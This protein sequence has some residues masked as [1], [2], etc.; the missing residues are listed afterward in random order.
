M[1][2][3]LRKKNTISTLWSLLSNTS[4]ISFLLLLGDKEQNNC[5]QNLETTVHI[6]HAAVL[7]SGSR[8]L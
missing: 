1:S 7:F 2:I 3:A 5:A 4:K 8:T 6:Q